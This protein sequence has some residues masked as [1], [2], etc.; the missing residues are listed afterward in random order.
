M[1]LRPTLYFEKKHA[2]IYISALDR[3]C[4]DVKHNISNYIFYDK[5]CSYHNE[6]RDELHRYSIENKEAFWGDEAKKIHWF[7]EP[8]TV[9]D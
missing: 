8:K 7:K 9:I 6:K 1:R 5:D 3:A 2:D 4:Y